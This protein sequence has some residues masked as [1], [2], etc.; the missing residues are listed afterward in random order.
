MIAKDWIVLALLLA[1]LSLAVPLS[2]YAGECEQ[3]FTGYN[4]ISV[5]GTIDS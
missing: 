5:S 2:L 4:L 1:L 3:A